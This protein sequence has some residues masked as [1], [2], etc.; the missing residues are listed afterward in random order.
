MT[1]VPLLEYFVKP[2]SSNG[3][4]SSNG[5]LRSSR[6]PTYASL[7]ATPVT[8][9]MSHHIQNPFGNPFDHP[10]GHPF[11]HPLVQMA[12][13]AQ[14]ANVAQVA[15]MGHMAQAM[16]MGHPV[17]I[18]HVG[19]SVSSHDFICGSFVIITNDPVTNELQLLLPVNHRNRASITTRNISG[20][21]PDT[22]IDKIMRQYGVNRSSGKFTY[23]SHVENDIS[24]ITYKIGV[25]Y[26]PRLSCRKMNSMFQ[27][28]CHETLQRVAFRNL[29]Y[30]VTPTTSNIMYAISNLSYKLT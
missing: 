6:Q 14:M 2:A 9:E 19:P 17:Q 8:V 3:R 18:R 10:L 16:H 1:S 11:G 13:M 5:S 12:Q 4:G 21:D 24:R 23:L 26:I 25:L 7:C 28:T 29:K 27:S 20:R 30:N 22:E 15:H